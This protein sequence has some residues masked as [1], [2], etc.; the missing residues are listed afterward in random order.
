MPA[1]LQVE[2]SELA[3]LRGTVRDL[4]KELAE[5][6]G[7]SRRLQD[8]VTKANA[9]TARLRME[10]EV[11]ALPPYQAVGSSARQT[12]RRSGVHARPQVLS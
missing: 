2:L 5:E 12:P 10:R 3:D 11:R 6:A 7:S 4:E 8:Q 9:E 1:V